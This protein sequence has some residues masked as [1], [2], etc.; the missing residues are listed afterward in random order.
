MQNE[1]TSVLVLAQCEEEQREILRDRF[2]AR[3]AL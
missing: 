1:K 2:G 3:C